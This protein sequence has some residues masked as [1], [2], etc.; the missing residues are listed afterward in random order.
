MQKG[1]GWEQL[2]REPS[3]KSLGI[4]DCSFHD[5]HVIVKAIVSPLHTVN[6]RL[7]I[8]DTRPRLQEPFQRSKHHILG[9][10]DLDLYASDMPN[11]YPA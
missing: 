4:E 10:E 8:K 3:A 7:G 6:K 2:H 5:I 9:L 11:P 1:S